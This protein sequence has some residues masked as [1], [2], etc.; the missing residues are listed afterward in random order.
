MNE[1]L[2]K[3]SNQKSFMVTCVCINMNSGVQY[4]KFSLGWIFY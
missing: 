1:Y 4:E 3:K 2:N